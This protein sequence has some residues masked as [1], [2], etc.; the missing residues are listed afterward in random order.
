M[1]RGVPPPIRKGASLPRDQNEPSLLT[2]LPPELRNM[3]CELALTT[4]ERIVI[5]DSIEYSRAPCWNHK[6]HDFQGL[7]EDHV[8]NEDL[9][10]VHGERRKLVAKNIN[11]PTDLLR[12]CRQ[13]YHEASSMLYAKNKF[14][15]SVAPHRHNPCYR[16]FRT[17]VRWL[18]NI[19]SQVKLLQNVAIDLG[20][21]CPKNC[22]FGGSSWV[23]LKPLAGLLWQPHMSHLQ[24][25]FEGPGRALDSRA[26]DH[27][28]TVI[29]H[30][31]SSSDAA[32]TLSTILSLLTTRDVLSLQ[33][34]ARYERLI[35][36]VRIDKGLLQGHVTLQSTLSENSPYAFAIHSDTV[37]IPFTIQTGASSLAWAPRPAPTFST[38][39]KHVK[40]LIMHY[41]VAQSDPITFDYQTTSVRGLDFRSFAINRELRNCAVRICREFNEIVVRLRVS[42]ED[43]NFYEFLQLRDKMPKA[44]RPCFEV[45]YPG[46]EPPQVW[47]HIVLLTDLGVEPVDMDTATIDIA[48]LLRT[49]WDSPNETMI[50]IEMHSANYQQQLTTR[51]TLQ[52]LRRRCFPLLSYVLTQHPALATGY[53]LDIYVNSHGFGAKSVYYDNKRDPVHTLHVPSHW[54]QKLSEK[55][56]LALAMQYVG[57]L[58]STSDPALA[59]DDA[60][61]MIGYTLRDMWD[62]MKTLDWSWNLQ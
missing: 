48:L 59:R 36:S 15:V 27:L 12:T 30:P 26:H 8:D 33:Q 53:H 54:P 28:S 7:E 45:S 35:G 56:L 38:L 1:V 6:S 47:P 2:I 25:V 18:R 55:Q 10:S 9:E 39:P 57:V 11:L 62:G 23:D 46:Q 3:I 20:S 50:S 40:H 42:S 4:P 16:Q 43:T 19:G 21:A 24:F 60:L 52:Q 44:I 31:N 41:V 58:E 14:L 17:T 37:R 29:E 61:P 22:G 13:I 51:M 5:V 32:S 34:Y 49:T